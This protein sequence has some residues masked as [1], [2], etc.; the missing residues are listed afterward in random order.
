MLSLCCT[1]VGMQLARL[2]KPRG[3]LI[4]DINSL[5]PQK[6]ESIA[7]DFEM[8]SKVRL[9]RAESRSILKS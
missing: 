3:V 7:D 2:L 4:A 1:A 8:L 6:A 9:L 5:A